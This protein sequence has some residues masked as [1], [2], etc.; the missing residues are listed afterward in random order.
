MRIIPLIIVMT[1]FRTYMP[2]FESYQLT[3]V[4]KTA[5]NDNFNQNSAAIYLSKGD[6]L[7]TIRDIEID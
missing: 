2:P 3:I 4:E 5:Y 6:T 1:P 7:R